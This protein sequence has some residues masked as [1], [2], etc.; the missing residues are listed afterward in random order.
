MNLGTPQTKQLHLSTRMRRREFA[1]RRWLLLGIA[2][3]ILLSLS[4]VLGHHLSHQ[5]S[6]FLTGRDH[7]FNMCLIALHE[8][9]APVHNGF[10]VLLAGGLVYAILDRVQAFRRLR[11]T[12]GNLESRAPVFGDP[13]FAAARDVGIDAADIRIVPGLPT[14]A[15]AAGFFAPKIFIAEQIALFLSHDQLV[16]VL[17]HENAHRRRRD[18]LRLSLL[19]FLGRVLF[20]LPAIR[21]LGDDVVDEAEIEA[22]DE[23][24]SRSS[25]KPLVLASALLDLLSVMGGAVPVGAVGFQHVNLLERRVKRLAGEPT[26]TGSH[27]TRRSLCGAGATLAAI[28]LSG[29]VMA[30]PLASETSSLPSGDSA[31][32]MQHNV[33]HC[34]HHGFWAVGHLF[35]LGNQ[36][37]SQPPASTFGGGSPATPHRKCPHE[38]EQ[39]S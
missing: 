25:V 34:N 24:V 15:F 3:L 10:H 28:W 9:L 16:A 14:P 13:F 19:R 8:L 4:P 32:E 6:T 36:S 17:A 2:A 23:A 5:A 20:F 7:L 37:G 31:A 12:L 39:P 1:H 26:D 18:P 27:V 35:C 38:Q 29:L 33:V 11:Q 22:D 21:T 30:H